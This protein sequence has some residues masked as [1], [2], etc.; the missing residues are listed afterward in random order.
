MNDILAKKEGTKDK[1]GLI[2]TSEDCSYC[3]FLMYGLETED[4]KSEKD[5]TS[6]KQAQG[7]FSKYLRTQ[8]EMD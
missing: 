7:V 8:T 6:E 5:I 2:F 1:T 3:N 4:A